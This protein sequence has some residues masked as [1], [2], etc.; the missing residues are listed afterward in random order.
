MMIEVASSAAAETS[1]SRRGWCPGAWRPMPSGDGWVLRIRVPLG[2][3]SREQAEGLAA[4]M[5]AHGLGVIELTQRAHLQ[6][7][8]VQ[9]AQHDTL[10]RG[11]SELGLLDDNA[12]Q[13]ARRNVLVQPWWRPGDATHS[14]ARSLLDRLRQPGAPTLPPKFGFAV[15]LGEAPCLRAAS[16]DVRIEPLDDERVVVR[17]D[18]ALRGAAVPLAQAADEALALA[19]WFAETAQSPQAPQRMAAKVAA[20]GLPPRWQHVPAPESVGVRWGSH[21]WMRQTHETMAW[22]GAPLGRLSA[23][24]WARLA[25]LAPLR[26]TP[27]RAVLLETHRCAPADED[28]ITDPAD[29]RLRVAACVGAPGCAQALRPTLPLALSLAPHV[30]SGGR[31]HVSGCAKGCAHPR[32]APALRASADGW[33]WIAYGRADAMADAHFRH[34]HEL[35]E[36]VRHMIPCS[37][38]I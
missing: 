27:W 35:I 36:A 8:G 31:L 3:L 5:R 23:A 22:V 17:A 21:P 29:P 25:R 20:G 4:L 6:W 14:V 15:D 10:L 12:E 16:A 24:A 7:R 34:D 13:E 38:P 2:R 9:P 33:D 37:L 30:P 18:G 28:W 19:A 32:P 1:V 11:L 26:L